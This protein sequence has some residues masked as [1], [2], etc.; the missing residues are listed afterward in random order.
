VN[1]LTILET[2]WERVWFALDGHPLTMHQN[3][4]RWF[5]K[6]NHRCVHHNI[7]FIYQYAFK[8]FVFFIL[9]MG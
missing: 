5:P 3:K 9:W 2:E 8:I 4:Q 6:G 7:I 1:Q